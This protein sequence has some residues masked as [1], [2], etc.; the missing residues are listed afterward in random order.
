MKYTKIYT[1]SQYNAY[2]EKHEELTISDVES[3]REE[4]ELLEILID[5]YES[6]AMEMSDDETPVETLRFLMQE[7]GIN[8]SQLAE[9]LGVSRQLISEILRYKRNISKAMVLKLAERFQ[10][11]SG[12]FAADYV[13][14][15][16][17][18]ARSSI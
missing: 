18:R 17:G 12:L 9:E 8:N 14:Q 10:V 11:N 2:C 1:L 6:R 4:I 5:D 7:N 15:P 16:D 13:L 3:H